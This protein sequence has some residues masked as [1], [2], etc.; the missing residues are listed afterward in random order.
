M[1]PRRT[2]PLNFT[3]GD[4]EGNLEVEVSEDRQASEAID[5]IAKDAFGIEENGANIKSFTPLTAEDVR[6]DEG[7]EFDIQPMPL[8]VEELGIVL[9]ETLILVDELRSK[10]SDL[11]AR[12]EDHNQRASH[13]I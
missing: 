6:E 12:I 4:S 7:I 2:R 8:Q 13:K 10:V 11:E 5:Q 9:Y 3:G 1:A